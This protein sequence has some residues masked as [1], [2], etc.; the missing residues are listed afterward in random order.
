MLP[1]PKNRRQKARLKRGGFC[2]PYPSFNRLLRGRDLAYAELGFSLDTS[3]PA[4]SEISIEF[5]AIEGMSPNARLEC[6]FRSP[7]IDRKLS[8]LGHNT[9]SESDP[10][11]TFGGN[12]PHNC[13]ARLAADRGLILQGSWPMLIGAQQ[14]H[15]IRLGGGL[16]GQEYARQ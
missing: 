5:D 11:Q 2:V 12:L 9:E 16:R 13:R 14:A 1:R 7:P 4:D 10:Q 15:Q 6:A 8:R 3:P